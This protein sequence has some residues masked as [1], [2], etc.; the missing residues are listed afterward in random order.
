MPTTLGAAMHRS[1]WASKRQS[2]EVLGNIVDWLR[3][4]RAALRPVLA[5]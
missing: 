4:Q 5:V 3:D 1:G 2:A